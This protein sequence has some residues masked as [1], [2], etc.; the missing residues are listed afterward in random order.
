MSP[1]ML[2]NITFT[3]IPLCNG[4]FDLFMKKNIL[5]ILFASITYA[6]IYLFSLWPDGT[7]LLYF[8]ML[9]ICTVPSSIIYLC[10]AFPLSIILNKKNKPFS[11]LDLVVYLIGSFLVLQLLDSTFFYRITHLNWDSFFNESGWVM[12]FIWIGAAVNF[13]LWNSIIILKPKSI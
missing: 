3:I 13:W 1:I 11:L 9:L 12:F 4:R 6:N 2:K 8:P 7:F 10:T 5:L